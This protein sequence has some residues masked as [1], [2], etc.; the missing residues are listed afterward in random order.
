MVGSHGRWAIDGVM[1]S[2]TSVFRL[3]QR[4]LA[5]CAPSLALSGTQWHTVAVNI[6]PLPVSV[7]QLGELPDRDVDPRL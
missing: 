2:Y 5:A 4:S 1:T 6:A 7:S 3:G